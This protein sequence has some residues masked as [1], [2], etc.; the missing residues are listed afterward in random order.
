MTS[1]PPTRATVH[2]AAGSIA[3]PIELY[4]YYKVHA[5]QLA[6]AQAAFEQARGSRPVR[7]L[8]RHDNDPVFRTWMEI[9][10]PELPDAA[11][12]ERRIAAAL[13]AYAQGPRHR[14]AFAA[15]APVGAAR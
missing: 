7:L 6:V 3:A 9:Y 15:V 14:E 4:V 10:G 1:S 13:G 12:A 11:D 5:D 2:P 8:Q